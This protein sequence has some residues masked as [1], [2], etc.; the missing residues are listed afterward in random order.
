MGSADCD[1][2]ATET[3]TAS[4]E[5][6]DASY[7]AFLRTIEENPDAEYNEASAPRVADAAVGS[8][9]ASVYAS[10]LG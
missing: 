3:D 10:F 8:G 7:D 5:K 6:L 9:V 1:G 4:L 2:S